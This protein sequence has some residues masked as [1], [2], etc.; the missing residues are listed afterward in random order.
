MAHTYAAENAAENAADSDDSKDFQDEKL[1]LNLLGNHSRFSRLSW[2][3]QMQGIFD[4]VS[5]KTWPLPS[6]TINEKRN[7]RRTAKNFRI[8]N[9]LLY[10]IK[11]EKP[12]A[13]K[14]NGIEPTGKKF[15]TVLCML[16]NIPHCSTYSNC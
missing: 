10:R 1:S 6:M 11:N 2:E 12:K 3:E 7:F 15:L 5:D 13:S 14:R 8:V 4:F 9:H 16:S